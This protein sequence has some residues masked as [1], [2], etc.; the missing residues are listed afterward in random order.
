M[1]GEN[2]FQA[3]DEFSLGRIDFLARFVEGEEFRA[4]DFGE[5]LHFSGVRRPFH[6][7]GIAANFC[8]IEVA[9]KGKGVDYFPSFLANFAE[10]DQFTF[11]T[12]AEF[13]FELAAGSEFQRFPFGDFAF[14]DG[15]GTEIFLRPEGSAGMHEQDFDSFGIPPEQEDARANPFHCNSLQQ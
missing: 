8:D 6:L 10:R 5:F 7:K 3:V 11:R 12:G 1:P 15:P 13:F 14:W 2:P 9:F 4:I